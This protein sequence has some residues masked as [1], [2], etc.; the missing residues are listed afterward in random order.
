MQGVSLNS[1]SEQRRQ[2]QYSNETFSNKTHLLPQTMPCSALSDVIMLL[3]AAWF[4]L[5]LEVKKYI[6]S[7][8]LCCWEM[9]ASVD[10]L[11]FINLATVLNKCLG[12][13]FFSKR[14]EK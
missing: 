8:L 1:N 9:S 11:F 13:C 12:L 10:G 14:D 4:E 6:K 2:H 3:V 7:L 5:Y